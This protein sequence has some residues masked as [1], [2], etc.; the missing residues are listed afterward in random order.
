MS[1]DKPLLS[2]ARFRAPVAVLLLGLL[3]GPAAAGAEEPFPAGVHT[4]PWFAEVAH[5]PS[6]FLFERPAVATLDARLANW[7]EDAGPDGWLATVRVLDSLGRPVPFFGNATFELTPRVLSAD[8]TSFEV[9][10]PQR[11]RWTS[12]VATDEHGC[13]TFR[14]PLRRSLPR[15]RDGRV[16]ASAVLGVRVAIAAAGV[17]EAESAVPL[18]PPGLLGPVWPS[19]LPVEPTSLVDTLWKA[20]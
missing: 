17:Y 12:T 7:D 11:L 20:R 5:Q 6:R 19:S 18:N 1:L 2:S 3:A 4:Q 14:L 16:P 10:G 8:L 13:A 9:A 15:A